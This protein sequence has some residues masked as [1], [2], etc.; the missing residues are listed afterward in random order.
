MEI[1]SS[2]RT[3]FK[4][5][6]VV[7]EI[8][9][10]MSILT[11]AFII[12]MLPIRWGALLS[13]FDPWMQFRQA[14][15]IVERGWSGF[16]E[17]FSWIDMERWYPYGQ[18]VSRS[19]YPGLPFL[20]A[21]VYLSLSSIGIHVNLLELAVVFPVIMSMVAVL[22]VYFLGKE[23]GGKSTGLLAAFALAV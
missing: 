9:A 8:A 13:E 11:I 4:S 5:R 22:V 1:K 14:E 17:Y 10:L 2:F 3:F 15:F 23:V 12:R 7:L 16:I 20:L 21:F 18:F 19:F 6:P